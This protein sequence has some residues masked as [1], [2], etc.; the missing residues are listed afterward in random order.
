[1]LLL[2]GEKLVGTSYD[3]LWIENKGSCGLSKLLEG[4]T[5]VCY[6]VFYGGGDGLL[7]LPHDMIRI[8]KENDAFF[9][10]EALVVNGKGRSGV[11]DIE[12]KEYWFY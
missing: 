11:L 2:L 5:R 6:A 4:F 9:R 3:R 1:M 12:T 10:Q 8:V 7:V